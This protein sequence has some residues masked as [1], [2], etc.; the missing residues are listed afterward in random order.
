MQLK[1]T[2]AIYDCL[3]QALPGFENINRYWDHRHNIYAAKIV[4]GEYYVTT[5]NEIITTVLGSC[6]SACIR[7]WKIGVGGMNHFM[8]PADSRYKSDAWRDS[9]VDTAARYGNVAME[10][11]INAI[12]AHGGRRENLEVKV[13]GGGRLLNIAMDIGRDNIDFIKKYLRTENLEIRAEDL[14]GE[15]PRKLEYFPATGRARVK[16]LLKT[17]NDTIYRREQS[18]IETLKHIPVEG[19]V[20]LFGK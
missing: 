13:F 9:P 3:P 12:L 5:H 20:E 1:N 15:Y 19:G 6:V 17:H 14:G 7:D 10:R 2:S 4:Q 11:L 18:Y 16:K 8:L